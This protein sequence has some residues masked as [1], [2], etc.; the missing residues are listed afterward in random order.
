MNGKYM[1]GV[2][3]IGVGDSKQFLAHDNRDYVGLGHEEVLAIACHEA[4]ADA[5]VN[6]RDIDALVM[7]Q[8]FPNLQ[9]NTLG[10]QSYLTTW[11]GMRGKPATHIETAC[12]T[13]YLALAQA[14]RD[15]AS[16][17][18]DC[19]LLA[20]AE[21]GNSIVA[22]G[23]RSYEFTRRGPTTQ[24]VVDGQIKEEYVGNQIFSPAYRRH[25]PGSGAGL[26]TNEI[27]QECL[28]MVNGDHRKLDEVA[29]AIVYHHRR[30]ASL[31]PR[32]YYYGLKTID[33]MAADEGVSVSEFMTN[34]KRFPW[35]DEYMRISH[36]LIHTNAAGAIV[37]CADEYVGK[38][39][40][41]GKK[42][43]HILGTGAGCYAEGEVN[44]IPR[45]NKDAFDQVFKMS[46]IVPADIDYIANC[47]MYAMED[48]LA[49]ED[50]G[51]VP[52]GKAVEYALEGRF[53]FDGDKPISTGGG[54]IAAGHAYGVAGIP[55]VNEA[56]R[57]MRG[58]CGQRQVKVPVKTVM[59]RG[60]GGSHTVATAVLQAD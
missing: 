17:Q 14:A 43:I 27:G 9:G 1:R 30:A 50:S 53:A 36:G 55:I 6:P 19:V 41:S 56:V 59:V 33:E 28:D 32:A 13:S 15:I 3:I 51:F 57:Q 34:D 37:L 10:M 42:P 47:D 23:R 45:A 44:H 54:D 26:C 60:M 11:I 21:F 8:V 29:N 16:G 4:F 5:G 2:S 38:Y 25:S 46:G 24:Y 22:P 12:A 52:K 58:E 40:T 7:P 48:L 18:Y 49:A 39:C 35:L 20:G 31:N